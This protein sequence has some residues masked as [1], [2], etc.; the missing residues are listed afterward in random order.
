MGNDKLYQGGLVGISSLHSYRESDAY[1]KLFKTR[2]LQV[3]SE[4]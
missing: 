3:Y 2:T 4:L 1:P